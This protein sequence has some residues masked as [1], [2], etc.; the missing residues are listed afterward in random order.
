MHLFLTLIVT[1]LVQLIPAPAQMQVRD[2][3]YKLTDKSRQ[4][5][6]FRL[7]PSCGLPEEGYTLEVTRTRTDAYPADSN[8]IYV[9][10]LLELVHLLLLK[11][12]YFSS[13]TTLF[14]S[15]SR[16]SMRLR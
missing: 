11:L 4:K 15:P 1:V 14:P 5:M 6:E 16:R 2:G 7:D 3:W 8:D 12:C 10:Y 13:V 9:V